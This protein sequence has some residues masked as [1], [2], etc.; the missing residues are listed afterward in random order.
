MMIMTKNPPQGTGHAMIP[1]KSRAVVKW[2]DGIHVA[3]MTANRLSCKFN[4]KA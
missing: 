4:S 1:V 3:G 2:F